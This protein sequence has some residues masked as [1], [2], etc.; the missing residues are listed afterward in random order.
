MNVLFEKEVWRFIATLPLKLWGNIVCWNST[1]LDW[2]EVCPKNE[3]DEI[4]IL[5]NPPYLGSN[6]QTTEQKNDMNYVF[7]WFSWYKKLDYISCWFFK[8]WLYIKWIN[9]KISLVS[10]NSINQWEQVEL[11]WPKVLGNFLEID[12]AYQSFKWNNNAKNNAKVIVVIIWIR[13]IS[14]K[15]KYIYSLNLRKKVDNINYYLA[16]STTF[17]VTSK[18]KNFIKSNNLERCWYIDKS[19]NLFFNEQEYIK[20]IN[21]YPN[22]KKFIK[23][24]IW[25]QEMLKWINKYALWITDD[26]L[27]EAKKNDDIKYR[28]NNTYKER[29]SDKPSH[30]FCKIKEA[31]ERLIIVP[32]VSSSNRDYIPINIYDKNIAFNDSVCAMYD[33]EIFIFWIISS[34]MHMSWVKTIAWRLKTDYRYSSTLVYNTFPFP[35]ITQKQKEIIE[36]H[37]NN[38]LDEREKHSEKTLA[39]MYDP[40]KMP[41]W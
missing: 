27:E 19:D 11:L 32:R 38:V 35:E 28:I 41:E 5:G 26:N 3:W 20:F 1:R 18:N 14:N 21:L 6:R 39:E 40:D 37:V 36:E 13:N 34:K 10:T 16:D 29:N 4:Y 15:N 12:Y 7:K 23:K 17:I 30:Q 8:W 31:K 24:L 22:A 33:P 25:S 9:A 2:E